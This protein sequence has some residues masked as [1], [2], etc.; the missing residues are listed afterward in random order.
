MLPVDM[1]RL[2]R[3]PD[4]ARAPHLFEKGGRRGVVRKNPRQI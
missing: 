2:P 4:L 3:A 1:K